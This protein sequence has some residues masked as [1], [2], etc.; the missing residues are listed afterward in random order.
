MAHTLLFRKFVQILQQARRANLQAEKLPPPVTSEQWRLSRRQFIKNS[1]AAG[2]AG[3]VMA[4]YPGFSRKALANDAELPPTVAII[5]GGLAG[6]NT[7]YQLQKAGLHAV[8]YEASGRLGGR[9]FSR[10]GL[11]GDNLTVELGAEFINSDHDDM[12]DLVNEFG[13]TLFNRRTD[14][15]NAPSATS[16]YYFNNKSWSE[17]ELAELLRPLVDQINR[18]A[19]L[20]DQE[21]DVYAPQFD[22]ISVSDYL[23]THA[24]LISQ[25]FIRTLIENSIRTEYGV[26]AKHSSA[27]Q[28]LF[29]LPTVDGD[30]VEL[31][32]YSDEAF[33]V[34]GG[35]SRIIEA[36]TN[37]LSGRIHTGMV[38]TRLQSDGNEGFEL[39]F[40]NGRKVEADFVVVAIPFSALRQVEINMPLPRKLRRFIRQIDLGKNEKLLAGFDERVWRQ[41]PGF[42]LEAW[43]DLGFSEVWDGAQRQ[44]DQRDGVLTYYLGG[45]EVNAVAKM[46]GG[47]YISGPEFTRRLARFIPDLNAHATA[48]Y[49]LTGWT[50]NPYTCGAYVNYKPGQLTRFADYFWIESDDPE[51]QQ[52][53]NVGRLVFAGEHLSD[54]YY[55]FMNGAAQTGRLAAR[56]VWHM[57]AAGRVHTDKLQG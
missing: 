16:A 4:G 24:S 30:S 3:L 35:N 34:Q 52:A 49:S 50:R 22:Q 20:I 18:D 27:L 54:E 9:V 44:T 5:G 13:L 6:L 43:T 33:T 51:Q 46:P 38:L 40:N 11:V 19:E 41:E 39:R 25:P 31:L 14:A 28:L 56:L 45:E 26:E 2:I 23:N 47:A 37:A 7:A 17:T 42:S 53:V 32:G 1:G 8:V 12:L 55:G 48:K 36:L 15:D 57:A 21:W 29:L 10:T